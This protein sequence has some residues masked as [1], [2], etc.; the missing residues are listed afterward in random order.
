MP[1]SA[2]EMARV[3]Q[4]NH[5]DTVTG[6]FR[7]AQPGGLFADALAETSLAV[8][9]RNGIVFKDDLQHTVGQ[10]FAGAQPLDIRR[11]ANDSVRIVADEVG[12]DQVRGDAFGL[13]LL[14]AGRLE[15][16]RDQAGQ[17][18]VVEV[19]QLSLS[20]STEYS[21]LTHEFL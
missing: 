5:R 12:F 4:G 6:A 19:H 14:A 3:S 7:H 10:N 21:V 15:D 1:A 11:H 2:A 13:V 20:A 8:H 9:N 18:R 17:R 16:R